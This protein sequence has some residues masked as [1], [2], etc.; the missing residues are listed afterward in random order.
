[1]LPMRDS[2]Q[3]FGTKPRSSTSRSTIRAAVMLRDMV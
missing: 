3:V 2:D 1:V